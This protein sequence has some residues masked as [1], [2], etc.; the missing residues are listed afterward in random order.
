MFTLQTVG[1]VL[2]PIQSTTEDKGSRRFS[3]CRPVHE[4]YVGVSEVTLDVN[5][6]M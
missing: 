6:T 5:I 2:A 1:L 4:P 3:Y